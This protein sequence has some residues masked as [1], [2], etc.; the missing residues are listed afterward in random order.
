MGVDSYRIPWAP[1]SIV[2]GVDSLLAQRKSNRDEA[3]A[4]EYASIQRENARINQARESAEEYRRKKEFEAK[5]AELQRA[6]DIEA[7]NAFPL[8]AQ[9]AQKSLGYGNYMGQPYGISFSQAPSEPP[10]SIAKTDLFG[11]AGNAYGLHAQDA[12][13][14]APTQK[15]AFVDQTED[16]RADLLMPGG[17]K[18]N[19]PS[20]GGEHPMQEGETLPI[21]GPEQE[22]AAPPSPTVD[23][24]PSPV[25]AAMRQIEE[26]PRRSQRLTANMGGQQFDVPEDSGSTGFGPEYDAYYRSLLAQGV[27]RKQAIQIVAAEH[28]S[29]RGQKAIAD[30]VASQISARST[31]REDR[32]TFAQGENEKYRSTA[33]ERE[34]IARINAAGRVAAAGATSSPGLAELLRLKQEGAP[35]DVIADRAAELK[36]PSKAWLP[37]VKETTRTGE[38]HSALT[39]TGPNGDVVG[40]APDAATKRKL[41]D[42]NLAFTQLVERTKALAD[43]VRANGERIAPWDIAGKQHRD[44]LKAAAAAAGRAY[45]Q[46]GVSNANIELE[47]KILGPAGTIGDGFFAGA[48]ADVIDQTLREAQVKHEAGMAIRLRSGQPGNLPGPQATVRKPAKRA[49]MPARGAPKMSKDEAAVLR[50]VAPDD[51][52]YDAAQAALKANGY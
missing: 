28:K 18:V 43:D 37:V 25:E 24:E 42:A 38:K 5:Q 34:K 29:D 45:H 44:S 32:Q 31:D 39:V 33:E 52:R 20:L 46:L 48:N 11:A 35:D 8:V 26:S 9:A 14:D 19:V 12:L 27:D 47:H 3:R 21:Y 16:G 15:G 51:P 10:P 22:A 13:A 7:R 49:A 4:D 50:S 41:D 2:P 17:D 6:H 1:P 30:R 23:A 40:E 36:I